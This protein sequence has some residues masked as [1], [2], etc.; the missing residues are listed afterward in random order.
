MDI[1][2]KDME[3]L[4]HRSKPDNPCSNSKSYDY[5]IFKEIIGSVG[6]IPPYFDAMFAESLTPC[7][8]KDDL[9][10]V[11]K[12]L[13]EAL[14]EAGEYEHSIPPCREIK[15]I[16][17]NVEDTDFNISKIASGNDLDLTLD[18]PLIL[19]SFFNNSK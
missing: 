1:N 6:C 17:V 13:L 18:I 11:A 19:E 8:T 16:G 3:I 2:V 12:K 10:Q 9:L 14:E 4:R 5:D 15:K 7:N